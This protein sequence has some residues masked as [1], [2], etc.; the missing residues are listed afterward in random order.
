MSS[1]KGGSGTEVRKEEGVDG[2]SISLFFISLRVFFFSFLGSS[3][4]LWC[5]CCCCRPL[6]FSFPLCL[7][8]SRARVEKNNNSITNSGSTRR[9]SRELSFF[10]FF[11]SQKL[12]FFFPSTLKSHVWSNKERGRN[13]SKKDKTVILLIS[14]YCLTFL[15]QRGGGVQRDADEA[16]SGR[17]GGQTER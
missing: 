8:L 5:C 9:K 7:S 1:I 17:R 16:G 14:F 2:N 4:A 13:V 15:V 11:H 10:F 3:F 6:S 12:S